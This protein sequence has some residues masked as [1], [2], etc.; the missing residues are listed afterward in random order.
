MNVIETYTLF[1]APNTLEINVVFDEE[2]D[3]YTLYNTDKN[4]GVAIISNKNLD[5]AKEKMKEACGIL[6]IT[7]DILQMN[8]C[9]EIAKKHLNE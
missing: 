4:R 7:T 3:Q 9:L 8:N 2:N 6:I 1:N 5:I